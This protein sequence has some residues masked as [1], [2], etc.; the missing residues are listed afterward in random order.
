MESPNGILLGNEKFSQLELLIYLKE[1]LNFLPPDTFPYLLSM[2][3]NLL[4]TSQH[5]KLIGYYIQH[6]KRI[7]DSDPSDLKEKS[8]RHIAA[9]IAF[10]S[11]EGR[12]ILDANEIE[13]E[14][15]SPE[16][17]EILFARCL[18][19]NKD[20][21][22]CWCLGYMI[23]EDS[24]INL[25]KNFS[26][27]M[28]WFQKAA[29]QG[30][31]DAQ[32]WIC[33]LDLYVEK[34]KRLDEEKILRWLMQAIEQ[35]H[36]EAQFNL[37]RRYKEGRGVP[38]DEV[39]AV[40]WF[41]CAFEMGHWG[42]QNELDLL[43]RKNEGKSRAKVETIEPRVSEKCELNNFYCDSKENQGEDRKN[44]A[45]QNAAERGDLDAQYQLGL[46]YE[47][48]RDIERYEWDV[49]KWYEKAAEQGHKGAQYNL[50]RCYENGIGFWSD[51]RKSTIW[52]RKAA[53]Q[54]H[55]EAQFSLVK[56]YKKE[57][58]KGCREAQF[59]LALCYQK[60][61]WVDKDEC[62]AVEWYKKAADQGDID[63][64]YNLAWCFENGVG[65]SKD[66]DEA[67]IWYRKAADLGDA[68]AP[69]N[70]SL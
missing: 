62:K 1:Y 60:G 9:Y 50:G 24:L 35:G 19:L 41:R 27:T 4:G 30:H 34:D 44:P 37:G 20:S 55:I 22:A 68:D 38:K 61:M 59:N 11:L 66:M 16:K 51:T 31:A 70:L 14:P 29:E 47:N 17:I 5:K 36:S 18:E 6:F 40:K 23:K 58:K 39:E 54:G 46:W 7:F 64:I 53:E 65:V 33:H 13:L 67:I 12:L 10:A 56:C 48:I 2:L 28:S 42:A 3:L 52:Y 57:A 63:A 8:I 21:L 25:E 69:C 49:V 26:E 43:Q 32:Y 15:L 45:L